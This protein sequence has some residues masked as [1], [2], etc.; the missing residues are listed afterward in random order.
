MKILIDA[1]YI[2][3]QTLTKSLTIYIKRFL[4]SI[5]SKDR[6]MFKALV[7]PE[8]KKHLEKNY[9]WMDYVVY[10]PFS[11]DSCNRFLNNI[12]R[13]RIYRMAVEKS[14]CDYL[15]VP[16]DLVTFSAVKVCLQ[17]TVV[18]HDMKSINEKRKLSL[19]F[20]FFWY[21]Y[22]LLIKH[23]KS[24]IAI[25]NYT[26]EDIIRFFP[27]KFV[28][29]KI[30]VVYNSVSMEKSDNGQLPALVESPFILYVN[31]LLP[32]KNLKTL[33]EAM[34]LLKDKIPHQLIVVGKETEYWNNDLL[35]LIRQYGLE[36]RIV[37]MQDITNSQLDTLYSKASLFVS[38][39]LKEGFGYTPIEAALCECPVISTQCEALK[40]TTMGLLNYYEPAKDSSQL[41]KKIL[42]VLNHPRPSTELHV[43]AEKFRTR[44][45]NKNQYKELIKSIVKQ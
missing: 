21:Y 14:G 9:P 31:A 19:S 36:N 26:K 39:S 42:E 25:S 24:V 28:S 44:Y 27:F 29:K 8:A 11:K 6:D 12:H 16:N 43:I 18:I 1:S 2:T 35:P 41:A 34:I 7:L 22:Y 32:Y 37:R 20:W 23:A 5:P 3:D 45:N 17:K 15:F 10:N 33:I 30:E 4:D 13:R 38:T 40:D